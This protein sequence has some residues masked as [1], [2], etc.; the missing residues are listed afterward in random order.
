MISL[1]NVNKYF[2]KGRQNEI[3]VI[4]DVSLELPEKGMVALYG[5]SG[6]G[7]T[8]L[9]NAIGG[10]DSIRSGSI[11]ID[12]NDISKNTDVIR[13]KYIGYIFQNYNLNLK[14]D[15]YE[16]VAEA[17]RLCGMD[18]ETEIAARVEA[19]LS[20]VGMEKYLHRLPD[21]L[22][23]GQKQRVAIARAI[24][25]NPAIILADEPTG[26]LDESNTI[27]IMDLLKS[28]SREHLVLIVTHESELVDHYCDKVIELKD[29]HIEDSHENADANGYFAREKNVVYLGELEKNQAAI[30]KLKIE[31]YG[32]P[33]PEEVTIRLVNRGG[34]LL[35]RCEPSKVKL[36]DESSEIV[37]SE[38]TFKQEEQAEKKNDRIDMSALAAFE[39][40]NYGRLFRFKNAAKESIESIRG[41][42]SKGNTALRRGLGFFTILTV[43]LASVMGKDIKAILD[44]KE[45]YNH[46]TF[47]VYANTEEDLKLLFDAY[48]AGDKGIDSLRTSRNLIEG[49]SSYELD[50]DIFESFSYFGRYFNS[51]FGVLGASAAGGHAVML[52]VE[53][54]KDMSVLY[55]RSGDIT[56][57]EAVISSRLAD[58]FVENSNMSFVESRKD[59]IGL[60]IGNKKIVG[61]VSSDEP[62]IYVNEVNM[63]STAGLENVEYHEDYARQIKDGEIWVHGWTPEGKGGHTGDRVT[64]GGHEF[65][66]TGKEGSILIES[67][68]DK[69]YN[70]IKNNQAL[71][72]ML[73]DIYD[74]SIAG[75]YDPGSQTYNIWV[76]IPGEERATKV[77]S[78]EEYKA[79]MLIARVGQP[80]YYI[81]GDDYMKLAKESEIKDGKKYVQVHANDVDTCEAFLKAHFSGDV[82]AGV[83]YNIRTPQFFYDRATSDLWDGLLGIATTMLVF[84]VFLCLCIYMIMRGSVMSRVKEIGTYRSIGVTK[85]NMDFRFMVESF[86]LANMSMLPGFLVM[87]GAIH[88]ISHWSALE[89]SIF[90][91]WW[92]ILPL[93]AALYAVTIICGVLPVISLMTKKP[94]Q[95]M[96]KYDV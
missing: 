54:T 12:G 35:L 58:I 47:Y 67:E 36:L 7:K 44:A 81:S 83:A 17:L 10:L 24:V 88:I 71:S 31:C 8:T 84:A 86:M 66:I 29:G 42:R 34:E 2:F 95:I 43:L 69:A 79:I 48:E 64:I 28:V 87:V 49:D 50:V 91:P 20:N 61:I 27:A 5:Q 94:A 62:A 65:L 4:N 6:C 40:K 13:N 32:D 30:G 90:L 92:M 1:K 37:F 19:A 75:S 51:P 16:N 72:D 73:G 11:E 70:M 85:K 41:R 53:L 3:H 82:P 96:A 39:G 55:G 60:M 33:L 89:M 93:L 74:Q 52:P 45:S 56:T 77:V 59:I 21:T 46:N 76:D 78:P 14:V 9:L 80:T 18:N 63:Y 57:A 22:S 26:N 68:C 23:G 38:K 15:I 25:K